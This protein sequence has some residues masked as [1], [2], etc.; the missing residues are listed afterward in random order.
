MVGT[1]GYMAPEQARGEREVDARADVFSLGCVLFE[2]LDRPAAVRRPTTSMAVLAQDPA[3][4]GAAR[5]R[6]CA[7]DA[8]AALDALIARMLAKEPDARPRDGAASCATSSPRCRRSA[9]ERDVAPRG[10][11][12]AVAGDHRAASDLVRSSSRG[13]RRTPAR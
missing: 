2:C 7:P 4:G 3:R 1:P 10:A 5:S 8:P 6:A 11:A 13:R 9:R 12:H